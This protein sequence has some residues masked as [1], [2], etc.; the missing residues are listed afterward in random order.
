[1]TTR[2]IIQ[3]ILAITTISTYVIAKS[4]C[5][6]DWKSILFGVA[7]SSFVVFVI[8]TIS[9]IKDYYRLA[10][11]HQT[12]TRTKI[13][14]TLDNRHPNGIYE[15]ITKRY[16]DNNVDMNISLT[17]KGDGEYVGE[18]FYEEGKVAITICL[19]KTNPKTG[20]G[21]YQ[22]LEKK[23]GY[24]MPDLGTY[25]IQVDDNGSD[26][27]FIYY[28]NIVPNGLAKGYEIWAK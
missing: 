13:T 9:S 3:I 28:S 25:T 26:R 18:A 12:Y 8:E 2:R 1:M 11:L 15:D 20:N 5:D 7:S 19:D 14:N 17:Y 10:I 24:E 6:S 27:I 23:P 22:Y 16:L 21:T 4:V